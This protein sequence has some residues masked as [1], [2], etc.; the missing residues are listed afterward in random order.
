MSAFYAESKRPLLIW[1]GAILFLVALT[2][3]VGGATRLTNSG[4]SI[5]E[6]KPLV[7]AIPPL[8]EQ[9]WHRVFELYKQIP[10]YSVE[11]SQMDL[12]G[13]KFIFF[14]EY[15]HRNMGRLLGVVC[16]IPFLIFWIQGR[17]SRAFRWRVILGLCLGGLQG[18]L[19]WYMVK[20]GLSD[21]TDVSHYRLA[22]HL[23]LAFIIFAYFLN[24]FLEILWSDR[25]PT[26]PKP[27]Q[28]KII[29]QSVRGLQVL[30]ALQI[31]YGAFVAGL[32]AGYAYNTFPKMLGNWLPDQAHTLTPYFHNFLENPTMI[33]F[34]HR[35]MGALVVGGVF[36]IWIF[37][38]KLTQR[39]TVKNLLNALLILVILQFGLGALTLLSGMNLAL[40]LSHQMGA[41]LLFGA[42]QTLQKAY[43]WGL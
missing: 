19:G 30:L 10:E 3:L 23:S 14:W 6:W 34:V 5:T 39:S 17:L 27:V 11:H 8:S 40:A 1:I 31:I 13:F 35:W 2:L 21:R 42:L 37:A 24:I 28:S 18:L 4:L 22:A 12:E 38:R 15:L 20:S 7:G 9:D 29:D 32:D 16:L 26:E 36:W 33:Q 25:K 43:R 41:L